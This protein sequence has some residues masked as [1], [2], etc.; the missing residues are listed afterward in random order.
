M[1]GGTHEANLS[2][3]ALHTRH[4]RIDCTDSTFP[5]PRWKA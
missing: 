4:M 1:Q 2:L 5:F 3:Q